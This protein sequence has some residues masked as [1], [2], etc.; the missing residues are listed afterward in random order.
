MQGVAVGHPGDQSCGGTKRHDAIALDREVALVRGHGAGVVR[1]KG[2]DQ[3]EQLHGALVLTQI[4]VTLE[5]EDVLLPVLAVD[6]ELA[7]PLLASDNPDH[8]PETLNPHRVARH[9][10]RAWYAEVQIEA[11]EQGRRTGL[12]IQRRQLRQLC[13]DA[14]KHCKVI[15]PGLVQVVILRALVGAVLLVCAESRDG[16]IGFLHLVQIVLDAVPSIHE[17]VAVALQE[18]TLA[19]SVCPGLDHGMQGHQH[20]QHRLDVAISKEQ[21]RSFFEG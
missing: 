18:C 9:T 3:A 5:Q 14:L 15:I 12:H 2:V 21:L 17:V 19:K 1:Q 7:G 8:R 11:V 16:R 4:F 20:V 13:V 6:A 10:V